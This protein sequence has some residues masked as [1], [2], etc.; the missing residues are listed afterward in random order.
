MPFR[1]D[2]NPSLNPI[3]YRFEPKAARIGRP[4]RAYWLPCSGTGTRQASLA[5]GEVRHAVPSVL[6]ELVAVRTRPTPTGCR[7]IVAQGGCF[8]C[9]LPRDR[10]PPCAL[11][12]V[13]RPPVHRAISSSHVPK[14]RPKGFVAFV[15]L[16][17]MAAREGEAILEP[18]YPTLAP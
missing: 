3:N 17:K 2:R 10:A 9:A 12:V 18:S 4:W 8:R 7:W 5:A 15:L 6:R 13:C 14:K 16:R 11:H 1:T